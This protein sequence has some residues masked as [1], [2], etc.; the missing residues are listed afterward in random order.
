MSVIVPIRGL[1]ADG[2]VIAFMGIPHCWHELFGIAPT[3]WW[4]MDDTNIIADA[5][6]ESSKAI[7]SVANACEIS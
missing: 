2:A 1:P 3:A 6:L 7:V 4:P 5:G